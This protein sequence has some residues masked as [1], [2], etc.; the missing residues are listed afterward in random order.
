LLHAHIQEQEPQAVVYVINSWPRDA[1]QSDR[2]LDSRLKCIDPAYPLPT[3]LTFLLFDEG[4][5]SYGDHALWDTFLKGVHGGI[6][7]NYRAVLFCSYGSPSARPLSYEIGMLPFLHDAPRVSLW[8]TETSIGLLLN[9]FEFNEVV[10]RHERKMNLHP[11]VLDL[12]FDL[13]GGHVGAI[14]E[15][16]YIVSH[17]VIPVEGTFELNSPNYLF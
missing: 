3:A 8:P 10:A 6:Y 2:S 11:D 16:L 5:D 15:L 4:Q 1:H 9:R 14:A 12:F 17:Q 13:T 7:Y